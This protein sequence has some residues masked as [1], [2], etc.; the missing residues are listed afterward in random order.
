MASRCASEKNIP[1]KPKSD[2]PHAAEDVKRIEKLIEGYKIRDHSLADIHEIQSNI[3]ELHR[4][5]RTGL[6]KVLSSFRTELA[7][8]FSTDQSPTRPPPGPGGCTPTPATASASF[9][10][11]CRRWPTRWLGAGRNSPLAMR[12]M[13]F[14]GVLG[15]PRHSGPAGAAVSHEVRGARGYVIMPRPADGRELPGHAGLGKI[16]K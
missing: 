9:R 11:W 15:P 8:W 10:P 3:C 16:D 4:P 2:D 13:F 7:R 5:S 12:D 6:Q 14:G 1:E